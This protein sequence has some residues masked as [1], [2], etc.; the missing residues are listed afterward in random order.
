MSF[1]TATCWG[2][3]FIISFT[4][5]ALEIAFTPTGAFGWYAA[6]CA[7]GTVYTY[8]LLPETKVSCPAFLLIGAQ[9]KAA[10]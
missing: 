9:K 7:F 8:F 6:W 2:F 4:W 5:P 1:A 10:G 3:N